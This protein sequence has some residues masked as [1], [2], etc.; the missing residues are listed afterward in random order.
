[1]DPA[2]RREMRCR[3]DSHAGPRH[4]HA[5]AHRRLSAR[6]P[7]AAACFVLYCAVL[8]AS[9]APVA[10]KAHPRR[11]LEEAEYSADGLSVVTL[12]EGGAPP[13]HTPFD[14]HGGILLFCLVT[15]YTFIGLAIVCDEYFCPSLELISEALNLSED[16]AGATF[17]AAGSSAP[18]LF[19]AIVTIFVAPGDQGVGTIVGSAV[20]N[21]CVIVG[22]SCLCAGSVLDLFWWPLTRDSAVYAISI[23]CMM[24]F[25]ADGAVTTTEAFI[26]TLLYFVYL[27]IMVVNPRIVRWIQEREGSRGEGDRATF[28]LSEVSESVTHL[29]RESSEE[30]SSTKSEASHSPTRGDA[31]VEAAQATEPTPPAEEEA[32]DGGGGGLC[33]RAYAVAAKPMEKMLAWTIPDCREDRWAKHYFLTFTMSIIWIGLLSF[34]MVDFASRAACVM[35]ISELVVGLC[36]LSVGTSVPDA[37]S[38]I[39]VAKQGQG[40]MAVCNALGSNIFNILLGLGLPWWINTLLTG[41]PQPVPGLGEIGEPVGL[42]VLYLALF[43]GIIVAGKWKLSPKVGWALLACQLVYTVWTLLRHLPSESPVIQF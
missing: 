23:V 41:K 33:S 31:D 39:I 29:K 16:V 21:L 13:C 1:M 8:L 24:C 28:E 18:E 9:A 30:R 40:N 20:F 38:S 43:L 7:I 36:V 14:T 6:M 17:M 34:V 11:G 5:S 35:G 22:L 12:L 19:T 27:G 42:L 15:L 10:S 37:L 32:A 2:R 3:Y 26:M 4:S 25:M